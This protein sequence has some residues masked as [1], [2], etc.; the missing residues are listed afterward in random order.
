M[1]SLGPSIMVVWSWEARPEKR[2]DSSVEVLISHVTRS[3][4]AATEASAPIATFWRL[5]ASSG[6]HAGSTMPSHWPARVTQSSCASIQDGRVGSIAEERS[7]EAGS[8]RVGGVVSRLCVLT[9][10]AAWKSAIPARK[11][12]R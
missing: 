12:K 2:M 6:R 3:E 10:S 5:V 11:K 1:R 8:G 4:S 7:V 9:D